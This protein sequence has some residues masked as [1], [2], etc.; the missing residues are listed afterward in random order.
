MA[1]DDYLATNFSN[2][3][4]FYKKRKG[5]HSSEKYIPK[6]LIDLTKYIEIVDTIEK[7]PERNS[8]EFNVF[9]FIFWNAQKKLLEALASEIARRPISINITRND[10][11]HAELKV[12][13]RKKADIVLFSGG[14]DSFLAA[15]DHKDAILV[16]VNRAKVMRQFA[17]KAKSLLGRRKYYEVAFTPK[18]DQGTMQISNSR[19][20]AFIGLA[21]LFTPAFQSDKIIV[22]ENGLLMYNP[23]IFEGADTTQ[24]LAPLLVEKIQK[25]LQAVY[26][27]EIKIEFPNKKLTKKEVIEKI[28]NNGIPLR[29]LLQATHSC[30]QQQPRRD[31]KGIK[32][33][34]VC[35]A[36]IVRR[37]SLLANHKDEPRNFIKNPF[38][39]H[40]LKG[41]GLL[42]LV[43]LCRFIQLYRKG[44]LSTKPMHAISQ[45]RLLF[46]RYFNEVTEALKYARKKG[47]TKGSMIEERIAELEENNP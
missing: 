25:L 33:C 32:M 1:T 38:R 45:D 15:S 13:K 41:N 6:R 18:A 34:G 37:V 20:L 39:E 11:P 17:I 46:E 35:Y 9:D 36:C 29:K 44:L 31:V 4:K 26:E 22:G 14:L 27:T 19:G 7:D 24:G 47:L 10:A 5:K 23:P 42:H 16:H 2:L 8:I 12:K 43:D 40:E 21:S 3:S 30:A 28:S